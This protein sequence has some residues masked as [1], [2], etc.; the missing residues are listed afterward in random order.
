MKTWLPGSSRPLGKSPRSRTRLL[1]MLRRQRP[2][3]LATEEP[4]RKLIQ[5]AVQTGKARKKIIDGRAWGAQPVTKV[6][7]QVELSH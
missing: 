4:Q 5:Q 3:A 2:E 1:A 7:P 6:K